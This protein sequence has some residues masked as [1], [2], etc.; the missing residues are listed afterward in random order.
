[1]FSVKSIVAA[2]KSPGLANRLENA[3][4]RGLG[5][6]AKETVACEKTG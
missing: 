1:M 2:W 5:E 3:L 6:D 4:N